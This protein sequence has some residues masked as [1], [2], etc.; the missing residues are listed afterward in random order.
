MIL[1]LSR[2]GL[3][4]Y[5]ARLSAFWRSLRVLAVP[6]LRNL[7]SHVAH[8]AYKIPQRFRREPRHN[9]GRSIESGVENLQHIRFN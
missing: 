4:A 5:P 6:N 3:Q 7:P 1:A 8:L 9:S 2:A